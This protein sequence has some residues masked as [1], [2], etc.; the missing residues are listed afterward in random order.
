[1]SADYGPLRQFVAPTR[2]DELSIGF[3]RGWG[4]PIVARSLSGARL[5]FATCL[6]LFLAACDAGER[7][8]YELGKDGSGNTVRLDR[9]TGEVAVISGDQIKTLK[10]ATKIDAE[11]KARLAALEKVVTW[12]TEDIPQIGAQAW[13]STSWRD[14]KLYFSLTLGE[15]ASERLMDEWT[16]KSEIERGPTPK[17]D[18]KVT[19]AG[20]AKAMKHSPFTVHLLDANGFQLTSISI[21]LVGESVLTRTVDETGTANRYEAKGSVPLSEDDYTRARRWTMKWRR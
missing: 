6:S 5:F 9:K 3:A 16:A 17:I 20:L 2:K 18:A 10:D 19:Q 1:M 11:R 7:S 15:L 12:G 14:G 8:R 13:L 4:D 21:G